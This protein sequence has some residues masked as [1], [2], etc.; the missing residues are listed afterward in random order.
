MRCAMVG[1]ER[2]EG[3]RDV[4]GGQPAHLAQRQRHLRVGR[5]GRMAADEDQPELVVLDGLVV[6][7]LGFGGFGFKPHRQL[8]Q[9]GVEARLPADAVDRLE[10]AGRHQ[11]GER[12]GRHAVLRPLRGG[13]HEGVVQRLPRRARNRRAAGSASPARGANGCGRSPPA[14]RR[15]SRRLQRPAPVNRQC[16]FARARCTGRTSIVPSRGHRDV[17][18]Q[19]D[20]LVEIARLDDDEAAQV[21]LGLRERP[22][23]RRQLAVAH[24]DR[25]GRGRAAASASA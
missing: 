2:Q 11:P 14:G 3:V 1:A 19:P 15:R 9:R 6:Q 16:P 17:A 21:L 12:I 8:L 23:R 13:R 7:H 25:D 18:G 5:Q 22:V 4:L 20:R 10:A 24:P